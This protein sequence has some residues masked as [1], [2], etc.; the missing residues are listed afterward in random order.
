MG[1]SQY[2]T[3]GVINRLGAFCIAT[4]ETVADHMW[5]S[6]EIA[7]KNSLLNSFDVILLSLLI[8]LCV[9][10]IYLVLT[11]FCPKPMIY[12]AFIGTFIF[13]LFAGIFVLAHP[14]RFFNPNGW[15]IAFG[16]ILIIA[17]LCFIIYL[18]CYRK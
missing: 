2:E 10:I 8:G 6:P 3:K 14:V 4:D 13:L 5:N 9:G 12:L 11:M 1:G 18:A 17:A 7:V 15:N 16:I